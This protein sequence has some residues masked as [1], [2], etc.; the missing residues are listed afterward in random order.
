[1]ST[2]NQHISYFYN[3]IAPVYQLIDFFLKAQKTDLRKQLT[4]L[5]QGNL[6][7]IGTGTGKFL[8]SF[9]KH[10]ITAIDIS[11]KML[12]RAKQDHKNIHFQLMDGEQLQ[13]EN[14]SFDYVIICH[15][16]SVTSEPDRMIREVKRVLKPGGKL[17]ILNHNTPENFLG[18]IDKMFATI[19]PYFHF[20]SHFKV[21]ELKSLEALQLNKENS[22]GLFDYT[23]LFEY[24]K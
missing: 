15:V 13:F 7:D 3:R 12:Q 22:M 1:M 23:K 16:L 19:S 17:F 18:Y 4:H 2:T 6:L 9:E 24:Q 20:K 14:N 11:R 8:G 10:Q 5:P 21:K